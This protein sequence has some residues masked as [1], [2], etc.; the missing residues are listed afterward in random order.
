MKILQISPIGLPVHPD[1]L[2]GGTERV[3]G[4]LD[5][6]YVRRNYDS[7]VAAPGDSQVSGTLL[8]TIPK[9]IW[10]S[11]KNGSRQIKRGRDINEE[12]YKVIFDYL[13]NGGGDVDI[14]H[15]HPGAGILSSK[16]YEKKSSELKMPILITLHGALSKKS[17]EKYKKWGQLQEQNRGIFF[18]VLSKSQKEQ[19]K[20]YVDICDVIYHGLPLEKFQSEEKP[21]DYLFSLGKISYEKGQDI[22]IDV[23]KKTGLKLIIGG[24]VHSVDKSYFK[25]KIKPYIDD[26][27]IKYVG[28]L[29]DKQKVG[30][31][32][33]A[34]A[35][36]MPIRW[37]EPFGL[38]MIESMA[39]GTPVIAFNRGSV[40]E[41]IGDGNNG[42]VV[43]NIK[44]MV[45]A[46]KNVEKISRKKCRDTVEKRF[47]I[48][49]EADNYL[50]LYKKLMN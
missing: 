8:D 29:N 31:Y 14:I 42:Y 50:R 48:Q 36:L 32:K 40:P 35:F 2:Y 39:C 11:E 47:S 46:V 3:I 37:E 9:S 28:A 33:N 19:F 20:K 41:V 13:F 21:G 23:A 45:R 27:Q 30:L 44:Q 15:D 4:F 38:V 25:E 24:E 18:N 43:N 10:N 26:D 16:P 17:S 7:I 34:L 6:E 1:I 5:K 49:K 22:A 12:H